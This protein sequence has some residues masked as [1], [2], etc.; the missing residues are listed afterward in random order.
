MVVFVGTH[1]V[2]AALMWTCVRRMCKREQDFYRL[3][4]QRQP[5][6]FWIFRSFALETKLVIRALFCVHQD[7]KPFLFA[8]ACATFVFMTAQEN[9]APVC[10]S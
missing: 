9:A 8:V 6:V 4:A 7:R 2:F 10:S 1:L 5:S 3:L